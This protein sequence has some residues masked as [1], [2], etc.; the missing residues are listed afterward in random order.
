MEV[1]ECNILIRLLKYKRNVLWFNFELRFLVLK[2]WC[3]WK[4]VKFLMDFVKWVKYKFFSNKVKDSLNKVYGNYVVNLIVFLFFKLKKFWLF[5][6]LC[7]GNVS[8]FSCVEY[9]G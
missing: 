2:K 1:V 5:V 9:D 3:L 7:I 4:K 8:I 6:K